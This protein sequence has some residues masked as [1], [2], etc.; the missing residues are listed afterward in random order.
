VLL[1]SS[2][3]TP[4]VSVY[5]DSDKISVRPGSEPDELIFTRGSAVPWS[6]GEER[7]DS[8]R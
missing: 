3:R 4:A 8:A 6:D 2:S 5:L 7:S 1:F